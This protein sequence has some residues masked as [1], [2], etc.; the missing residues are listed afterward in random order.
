MSALEQNGEY[1]TNAD[2]SSLLVG[3]IV[4]NLGLW[5]RPLPEGFG[6]LFAQTTFESAKKIKVAEDHYYVFDF[7]LERDFN[8][9][10]LVINNLGDEAQVR[11]VTMNA[12]SCVATFETATEN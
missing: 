2:N 11:R 3:N 4:S 6:P 5:D 8:P 10:E 7:E 12:R 9:S 1:F